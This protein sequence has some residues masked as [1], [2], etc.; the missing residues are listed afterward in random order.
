VIPKGFAGKRREWLYSVSHEA[1]G[2]VRVQPKQEW[3]E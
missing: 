2:C 1:V 3:D